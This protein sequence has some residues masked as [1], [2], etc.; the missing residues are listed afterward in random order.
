[1]GKLTQLFGF[2]TGPWIPL[3]TTL[4]KTPVSDDSVRGPWTTLP[5]HSDSVFIN[6]F[7][8]QNVDALYFL[9]F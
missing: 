9:D 3:D 2:L 7:F 1:M 5:E 4:G 8:A 6:S